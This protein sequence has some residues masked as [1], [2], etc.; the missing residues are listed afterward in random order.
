MKQVNRDTVEVTWLSLW[1]DTNWT[2]CFEA[3]WIKSD[4]LD[5]I[6]VKD[7]MYYQMIYSKPVQIYLFPYTR[8]IMTV[9]LSFVHDIP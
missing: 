4:G 2:E 3:A 6:Q 9:F 8:R 7:N 5:D 1:T